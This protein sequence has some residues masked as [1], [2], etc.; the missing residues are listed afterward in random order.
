MKSLFAIILMLS[1]FACSAQLTLRRAAYPPLLTTHAAG[2]GGASWSPTNLT[3]LTWIKADALGLNDGD[4]VG[5]WADQSGHG[6]DFVQST[7]G[8]KPIYRTNICAATGLPGV[9]FDGTDDRLDFYWNGGNEVTIVYAIKPNS[10][11]GSWFDSAPSSA[12]VF[13]IRESGNNRYV[14]AELWNFDPAGVV[15]DGMTN[16]AP[17]KWF[18]IRATTSPTRSLTGWDNGKVTTSNYL[19]SVST[20]SLAWGSPGRIGCVNGSG[21]FVNGHLLE[22]FATTTILNGPNLT[23]IATYFN[24]R[25]GTP[26][27][28]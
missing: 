20:T 4:A 21:E 3:L 10:T 17:V 15:A 12:N 18:A 7:A 27:A 16:N 28:N 14:Y 9:K 2:G 5:T 19:S 1:S 11:E 22:F 25:Y 8:Y 23:N 6:A 26:T 24:T 13:R